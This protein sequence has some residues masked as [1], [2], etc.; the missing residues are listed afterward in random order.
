MDATKLPPGTPQVRA[1]IRN[2]WRVIPPNSI[3]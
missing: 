2:V 1:I 3:L